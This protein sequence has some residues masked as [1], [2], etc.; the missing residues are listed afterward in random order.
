M[1]GHSFTTSIYKSMNKKIA[2]SIT[3]LFFYLL[4]HLKAQTAISPLFSAQNYWA[5]KRDPFAGQFGGPTTTTVT[6][7]YWNDV[8]A[9]GVKYMRVGGKAY[10]ARNNTPLAAT[11]HEWTAYEL[12]GTSTCIITE[13]RNQNVEPIIQVPIDINETVAKNASDAATLVDQVNNTYSANVT[14]WE[15]GNEPDDAY[16]NGTYITNTA[17]VIATYIKAVS[18]AMKGVA[19]QSGIKMIGPGLAAFNPTLD[20]LMM[21]KLIG[22]VDDIT[23]EISTGIKYIDY[24]SFHIYP[25]RNET[26]LKTIQRNEV[27][28]Y[29]TSQYR[30]K[31]D[32]AHLQGLIALCQNPNLKI[33]ITEANISYEQ[34][35]DKKGVGELGPNSYLA[36]QFW[37]EMEGIAMEKSVQFISYWSVIEGTSSD[38]HLTDIGYLSSEY[39]THRST[40]WHQQLMSAYYKSKSGGYTSNFYPGTVK[41]INS[42]PITDVKACASR[43]V[44]DDQVVVTIMNQKNTGGPYNLNVRTDATAP[45]T[46]DINISLSTGVAYTYTGTIGNQE[47]QWLVYDCAG[48]YAGKWVYNI[49]KNNSGL[50]PEWIGTPSVTASFSPFSTTFT[51]IGTNGQLTDATLTGSTVSTVWSSNAGIQYLSTDGN[52]VNLVTP[53]NSTY[54]YNCISTQGS[55]GCTFTQG[56][57]ITGSYITGSGFYAYMG[58]VTNATCGRSNGAATVLGSSLAT[59]PPKRGRVR[60]PNESRVET[61]TVFVCRQGRHPNTA[62]GATPDRCERSV[63]PCWGIANATFGSIRMFGNSYISMG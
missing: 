42:T 57:Q 44:G 55:S 8:K 19:G 34:D 7:N 28:D 49:T 14:Y 30:L 26:Y 61:H 48:N 46:S 60:D 6:P 53:T 27:I 56:V 23:G 4:P 58:S 22:G 29:L 5:P 63:P 2:F 1:F 47:T 38:N 50:P 16:S 36:G 35:R 52:H 40:Y 25:F 32:L 13:L 21:N 31:E 54:T 41:D 51:S 10:D 62:L 3:V 43:L 59:A 11:T 45:N 24:V 37:T 18:T 20:G 9:S 39:N 33:A 15:I 12:A 17:S